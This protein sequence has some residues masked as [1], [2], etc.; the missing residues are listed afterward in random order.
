M[1]SKQDAKNLAG[2][3]IGYSKLPD[4]AVNIDAS[5]TVF[6]RFANNGI[7]TSGYKVEHSVSI[8]ATTEDNRSGS[9]SVSEWDD[10]ALRRGVELAESMARIS[11]PNPEAVP[12][13]GP[14]KYPEL[15]NFEA[16]TA[17]SRGDSL[18][19]HIKAIVEG[20]KSRKLT[21]AGFIQKS[22][23]WTAVANKRGLFGYHRFTDANLTG[24]VRNADGTSSG[25]A[26][27]VST[28]IEDLDGEAAGRIAIDKCVSGEKKRRLEPGKY[29]VILEPAAVSDLVGYLGGGFGARG[30]EQGQSFL[31]KKGGEAGAT[32]LGEKIFPEHITLRSVPFDPRLAALPWG[33]SL[34]PNEGMTWIDKGV[35]RNLYYDR[36]WAEKAG[37]KPT[38]YPGNLLLEGQEHSLE[39]LIK[40]AGKAVLVTRLW[41]I[42]MLQ[43]QSLQVT[44]LTRDGVFLVENGK[45]SDPVMNFR[46]NESPVRV[47]EN[48]KMMT[49][50][51]RAQGAEAGSSLVPALMAADFNFA[52]ISDAV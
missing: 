40:A 42:R 47:L 1:L 24:T 33:P 21:G 29:T 30:A 51:G 41:Y 52:S 25:W 36:F 23:N 17:N 14:Q 10:A 43:P 26:S 5:D 11:Q 48:T 13:L 27:Q 7:T 34:L 38:P 45:I 35:V 22:A 49:R 32:R 6:I 44:G 28:S 16:G 9:A 3:V 50:P 37:R 18:I 46:W 31:S 12:A 20:C 15:E 4:C 8:T 39:D 2:K 19:G